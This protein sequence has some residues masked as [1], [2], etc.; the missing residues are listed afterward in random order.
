[1]KTQ[2]KSK[3]LERDLEGNLQA[4]KRI[5]K[6][7]DVC[8]VVFGG[9]EGGGALGVGGWL[10]DSSCADRREYTRNIQHTN[11]T[12]KNTSA[13]TKQTQKL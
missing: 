12:N 10:E 2:H 5:S 6:C 11:N 1:M 9:G 8:V 3:H 13:A 7:V 4:Q